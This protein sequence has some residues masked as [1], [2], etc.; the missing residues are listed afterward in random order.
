MRILWWD[1]HLSLWSSRQKRLARLA[2]LLISVELIV[3][4]R[5]CVTTP[6]VFK[7]ALAASEISFWLPSVLGDLDR[8]ILPKYCILLAV[9]CTFMVKNYFGIQYRKYV[10]KFHQLTIFC[11]LQCIT[12]IY[13]TCTMMYMY[14]DNVY[15]A[16]ELLLTPGWGWVVISL[17]NYYI[18]QCNVINYY[19]KLLYNI[20]CIYIM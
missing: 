9:H 17:K 4:S 18:V 7:K 2:R 16:V 13:C 6:I 20:H 10:Q 1:A 19:F 14:I 11:R 8:I 3:C 15:F 12:C 5:I